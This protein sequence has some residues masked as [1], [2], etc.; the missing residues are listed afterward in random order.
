LRGTGFQFINAN[1]C[2]VGEMLREVVQ[3]VPIKN[4]AE[5]GIN[6]WLSYTMSQPVEFDL[7]IISL[8]ALDYLGL[9]QV[10]NAIRLTNH[11]SAKAF[12]KTIVNIQQMQNVSP[13]SIPS[14]LKD[15]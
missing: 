13:S 11:L 6:C 9:P 7:A 4:I 14:E 3:L 5:H 15:L 2:A 10:K 12:T 1:H 8:F